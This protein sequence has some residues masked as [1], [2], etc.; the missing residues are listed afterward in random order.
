MD[1]VYDGTVLKWEIICKNLLSYRS[2]SSS[3]VFLSIETPM[4]DVTTRHGSLSRERF[5]RTRCTN[6]SLQVDWGL[7]I[8][9]TKQL[10]RNVNLRKCHRFFQQGHLLVRF[11][12]Q[13][14]KNEICSTHNV[15]SGVLQWK[16]I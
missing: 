15:G 9:T 2:S 12:T 13:A 10:P 4:I 8:G 1:P 16:T 7:N 5:V 11:Q 14:D 3:L 6:V